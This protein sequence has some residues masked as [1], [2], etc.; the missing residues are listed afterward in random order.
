[1][2]GATKSIDNPK[3]DYI[4]NHWKALEDVGK[5]IKIDKIK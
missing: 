2:S 5:Y 4:A 1:V 3:L